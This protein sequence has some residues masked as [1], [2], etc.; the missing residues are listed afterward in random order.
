MLSNKFNLNIINNL[1]NNKTLLYYKP[2]NL[3]FNFLEQYSDFN[4]IS[5]YNQPIVG[6]INDNPIE[7]SQNIAELSLKNH[8]Y[9][10]LLFHANPPAALKKEDKHILYQKLKNHYKIFFSKDIYDSWSLPKDKFT[11]ITNFGL[12]TETKVNSD[13]KNIVIINLNNNQILEQL[14]QNL[15]S[16]FVSVD[17]IKST[18]DTTNIIKNYKIAICIENLYNSMFCAAQGCFVLSNISCD[19]NISSILRI[20]NLSEI[21]NKIF[22]ILQNFDN[23]ESQITN[24]LAYINKEYDI[25]H[26]IGITNN[27]FKQLTDRPFIYEA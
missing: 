12:P 25:N 10:I 27:I 16:Q 14:Y 8:V 21:P 4:I 26:H 11:T 3:Y 24:S 18:T 17:I 20:D 19:K 13:K 1:Y 22:Q 23:I 5:I 9:S 7:Y 2:Q 15:K 6:I